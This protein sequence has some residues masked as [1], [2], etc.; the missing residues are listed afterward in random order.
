MAPECGD[1]GEYKNIIFV[2]LIVCVYTCMK[3]GRE[4]IIFTKKSKMFWLCLA[5]GNVKC[6]HQCTLRVSKTPEKWSKSESAS[7]F[8]KY[9][10]LI[11]L[12]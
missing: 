7:S 10:K 12:C 3:K 9:Y 11:S 4:E 1:G 5:D 2:V 8:I 6:E